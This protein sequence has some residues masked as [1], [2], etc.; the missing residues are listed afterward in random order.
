MLVVLAV[1]A[2]DDDVKCA[3]DVCWGQVESKV[4]NT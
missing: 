4:E 1:P 3:C 2:H